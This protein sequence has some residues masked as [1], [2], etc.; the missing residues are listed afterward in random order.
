[1][2]ERLYFAY[3][4]N[5]NLDQMARRCPNAEVVAPVALNGYRLL[6]R[7]DFPNH[8]VA[9]IMPA[10]T[11][12][13]KGLLWRLTP[14]CEQNLDYYEG[15]PHLYEKKNVTVMDKAGNKYTVM[16]YVMTRELER[17]PSY[18]SILYCTGIAQG[19]EQNGIPLKGLQDALNYCRKEVS[20]RAF[21][22]MCLHSESITAT[23]HRK[24]P[25]EFER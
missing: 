23:P 8:G 16:A 24:S 9:T 7:G 25:K 13:V 14:E 2:S 22:S 1:M 3:G 11:K 20:E 10:P 15:F 12:Q 5:I 4:S 18:P 6:F 19:Y 21:H 17:K